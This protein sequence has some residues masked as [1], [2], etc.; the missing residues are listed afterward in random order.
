MSTVFRWTEVSNES[1]SPWRRLFNASEIAMDVLG[2][3]P[4]CDESAL[5]MWFSIEGPPKSMVSRGIQYVGYGRRWEWCSSCFSYVYMPDG[6]VS[7]AWKPPFD[8]LNAD[9]GPTPDVIEQRRRQYVADQSP[10]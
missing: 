4:I 8:I 9:I 3:C 7:A 1:W 10:T 5:H 6:L 2:K